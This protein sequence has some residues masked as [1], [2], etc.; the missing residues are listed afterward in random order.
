MENIFPFALLGLLYIGTDP[1]YTTG[2]LC[3]RVFTGARLLHTI[4]Y[5]GEIPQPSRAIMF[6]IALTVNVYMAVAIT[7]RTM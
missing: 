2:I 1:V 3:F 4:V 6:G 5:L 7:L